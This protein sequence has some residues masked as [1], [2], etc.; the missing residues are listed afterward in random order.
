MSF[1]VYLKRI[2]FLGFQILVVFLVLYYFSGKFSK[3]LKF[4]RLFKTFQS[5]W[6]VACGENINIRS[7]TLRTSQNKKKQVSSPW[8]DLQSTLSKCLCLYQWHWWNL[9]IGNC[10]NYSSSVKN[11]GLCKKYFCW[12]LKY[13][14]GLINYI[15]LSLGNWYLQ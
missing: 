6:W 15:H 10:W 12:P 13:S 11:P 5:S 1:T 3:I 8:E 7:P 9:H 2:L 14:K 4:M